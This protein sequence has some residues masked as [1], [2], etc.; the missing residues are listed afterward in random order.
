MHPTC[1]PCARPPWPSGIPRCRRMA[2]RLPF[3]SRMDALWPDLDASLGNL[4]RP[5][6][7]AQLEAKF[8]DQATVLEPQQRNAAI[9]ACWEIEA[10]QDVGA[11]LIPLCV[12]LAKTPSGRDAG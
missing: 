9:A 8:R 1:G 11:T 4:K 7:D 10:L 5:L 6:T 12:P 3:G 2:W